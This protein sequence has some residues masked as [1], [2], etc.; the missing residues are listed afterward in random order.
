MIRNVGLVNPLSR[1]HMPHAKANDDVS[2]KWRWWST[3]EQWL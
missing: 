3:V 1:K 2:C